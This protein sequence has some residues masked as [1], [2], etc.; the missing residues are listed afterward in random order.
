M[1]KEQVQEDEVG[2][3]WSEEQR[4]Q[5]YEYIKSQVE[6]QRKVRNCEI[7]GM[8]WSMEADLARFQIW[9]FLTFAQEDEL[10]EMLRS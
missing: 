5:S 8:V 9:G 7:E 1:G 6:I 2:L 10:V 4:K 3:S